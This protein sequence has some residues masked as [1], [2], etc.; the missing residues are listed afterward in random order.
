[1]KIGK[2]STL[3]MRIRI[4]DPRGIQ[5]GEDSIIG[6]QVVLDGRAP[7]KIGNHVDIATGAMIFNSEHDVR[8]ADFHPIEETTII[9]DY[10]FVGPNA[11]ILPGITLGKGAVVAAG[12]V[13]TK[14]VPE[15]AIV[16]GV[17][18]KMITERPASALAYKLGR[19]RWFQ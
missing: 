10:V 3:H 13:V 15:R 6:E 18:A 9:E 1:M 7:L 8:A 5:I 12:A 17:P 2:G 16:A 19:A 4:Y 11:I 14:D